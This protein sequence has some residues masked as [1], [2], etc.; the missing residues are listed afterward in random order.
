MLTMAEDA[1]TT[2][3]TFTKIECSNGRNGAKRVQA[4]Q[5]EKSALEAEPNMHKSSD[6]MYMRKRKSTKGMKDKHL[7]IIK[8][9]RKL[10]YG[11]VKSNSRA[12]APDRKLEKTMDDVMFKTR[13][14]IANS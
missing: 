3:K 13:M 6:V 11:R 4:K 8:T 5:T 2:G 10:K 12:A 1:I 14:S 9:S 7:E